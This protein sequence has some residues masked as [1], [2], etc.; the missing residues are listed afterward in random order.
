M[1]AKDRNREYVLV[2]T[3]EIFLKNG[4]IG[5][6]MAEI[7]EQVGFGVASLYRYFGNRESLIIECAVGLWHDRYEKIKMTFDANSERSGYDQL[8]VLT[9]EFSWVIVK[10]KDFARILNSLD[11]FFANNVISLDDR[12]KYD[13]VMFDI[14]RLFRLAYEK[15]IEDTSIKAIDSFELFFFTA[16]QTLLSFSQKM[17]FRGNVLSEDKSYDDKLKMLTDI[18]TAYIKQ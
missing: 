12:K 9:Q 8:L 18:F 16:T 6:S 5:V 1:G 2:K 11:I 7:A 17:A 4:I 13:E 14:Y 15:G 10:D 3:K